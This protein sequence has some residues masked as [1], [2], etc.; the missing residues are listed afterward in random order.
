MTTATY[1]YIQP[2]DP[3]DQT[4]RPGSLEAMT[5]DS[6]N[7]RDVIHEMERTCVCLLAVERVQRE[8]AKFGRHLRIVRFL[9]SNSLKGTST[10][11][12][13]GWWVV[14][15]GKSVTNH[16]TIH[17]MIQEPADHPNLV[18]LAHRA[19]FAQ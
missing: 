2:R 3:S 8:L 6:G 16:T 11:L 4:K 13:V 19:A 15:E 17:M 1:R 5:H 9:C 12:V 7:S 18:V 14:N 10:A